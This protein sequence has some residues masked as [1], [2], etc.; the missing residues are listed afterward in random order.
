MNYY[1]IIIPTLNRYE[2][3]KD[4]IDSLA[5]CI[6]AENTPLYISLDYPPTEEYRDGY[7]K[8]K[9]YLPTINGF[10]TV[11]VFEQEENLGS[12]KN[13][14]FLKSYVSRYYKAYILTEDDN[15][16]SPNFLE[17]VN[18][19]L[20]K[21]SGTPRVT[22]IS[23]YN[24]VELYDQNGCDFFY[25][26]VC[27]AWGVGRWF[28]KDKELESKM[29][30]D[31]FRKVLGSWRLSWKVF[32]TNA[33][34]LRLL[35][36]MAQDQV[37]W[38]DVARCII[39]IVEDRYELAPAISMSKNMGHDGSGEHCGVASSDLYSKQVIDDRSSIVL[40]KINSSKTFKNRVDLFFCT[41]SKKPMKRLLS[42]LMIGGWYMKYR[43]TRRF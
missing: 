17:Y 14:S 16:F 9:E 11:T 26:P 23:G 7:N 12:E 18:L 1:P 42:V 21:F 27:S 32:I 33:S 35:M 4:C 6:G 10:K 25:R 22:S 15:I 37:V 39:N 36:R 43:M 40:G 38:N 34:D 31:F 28:D 3:L 13:C 19:G 8:I 24:F 29:T 20:D 30:M 41:L 5:R 2:H